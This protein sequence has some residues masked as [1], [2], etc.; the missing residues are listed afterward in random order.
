LIWLIDCLIDWFDWLIDWLIVKKSFMCQSVDS[1]V[2]HWLWIIV[3][4]LFSVWGQ[5]CKFLVWNK[6]LVVAVWFFFQVK[7][8]I[9]AFSDNLVCSQLARV[10]LSIFFGILTKNQL[11][12]ST[13]SIRTTLCHADHHWLEFW[14]GKKG[15]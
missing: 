10:R 5:L 15:T 6:S 4:C 11:G 12:S 2:G 3:W 9:A 14:G 1:S 7:F 13:E 8:S